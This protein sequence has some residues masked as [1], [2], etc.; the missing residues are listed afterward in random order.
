MCQTL[1]LQTGERLNSGISG[2]RLCCSRYENESNPVLA[3]ERPIVSAMYNET[4]VSFVTCAGTG[5]RIWD[6]RTGTLVQEFDDVTNSEITCS[7][8]DDRKRKLFVGTHSGELKA[9]LAM[10]M[11]KHACVAADAPD[12]A[13]LVFQLGQRGLCQRI[14]VPSGGSERHGVLREAEALDFCILGWQSPYSG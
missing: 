8:F 7:I 3:D 2:V 6:G 1:I 9:C 11:W 13:C 5:V 12:C 10:A 14:L 4:M